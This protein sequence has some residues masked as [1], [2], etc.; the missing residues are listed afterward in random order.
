[1]TPLSY[2]SYAIELKKY[3]QCAVLLN[4]FFFF[5]HFAQKV[6]KFHDTIKNT[7]FSFTNKNSHC[8]IVMLIAIFTE[9]LLRIQYKS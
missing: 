3:T 8:N 6:K 7:I 9:K 2:G 5:M 4:I 1:M